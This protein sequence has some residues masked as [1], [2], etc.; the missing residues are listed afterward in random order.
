M[1]LYCDLLVAVQGYL[2]DEFGY[3][4]VG[5]TGCIGSDK[6]LCQCLFCD[7]SLQEQLS[8]IFVPTS[9]LSCSTNASQLL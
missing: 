2:Q 6:V 5:P 9:L 4:Y 8:T 7:F 1:I 3:M